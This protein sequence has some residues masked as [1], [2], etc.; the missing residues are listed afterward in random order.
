MDD[1]DYEI[2]D[3]MKILKEIEPDMTRQM[4]YHYKQQF[5]E[6]KGITYKLIH[7]IKT[8]HDEKAEQRVTISRQ[9][10][11]IYQ[12]NKYGLTDLSFQQRKK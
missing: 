7:E 4:R 8:L 1:E 9:K 12:F 11:E 3:Y 10:N 2:K 6:K 5:K